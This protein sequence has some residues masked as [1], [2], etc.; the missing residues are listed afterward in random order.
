MNDKALSLAYSQA[1]GTGYKGTQEDFYN[2]LGSNEEAVNLAYRQ[3]SD[4]G[5]EGEIGAFSDLLGLKKKLQPEVSSF[6]SE[7]FYGVQYVLGSRTYRI[8]LST[9]SE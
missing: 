6:G 2:L 4:T 9:Y 3:A 7:G 8:G 1:Q 5:Y